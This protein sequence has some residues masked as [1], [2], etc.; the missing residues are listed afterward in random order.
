MANF[1]QYGRSASTSI[2][3]PTAVPNGFTSSSASNGPAL[4]Q[5]WAFYIKAGAGGSADDVTL[6][7]SAL[8]VKAYIVSVSFTAQATVSMGT[9]TLRDAAGGGGN[10]LSAA[11][12]AA[13]SGAVASSATAIPATAAAAGSSVFARRS[14][15]GI[16]GVLVIEY[17]PTV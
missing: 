17:V 1:D 12:T 16:A 6:F 9:I 4:P 3:G 10:A 2:G 5:K 14:D 7:S 15:S 11:V 13:S 8:P